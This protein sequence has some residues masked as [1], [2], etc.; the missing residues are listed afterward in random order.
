MDVILLHSGV[1][2]CHSRGSNFLPTAHLAV[3]VPSFFLLPR[4]WR[5]LHLYYYTLSSQLYN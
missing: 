5:Y 1:I 2:S 3:P 4:C